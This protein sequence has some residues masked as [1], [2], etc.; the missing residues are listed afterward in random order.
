ME[1]NR[2]VLLRMGGATTRMEGRAPKALTDLHV[3]GIVMGSELLLKEDDCEARPL[4]SSGDFLPLFCGTFKPLEQVLSPGAV[5]L[6]ATRK[7]GSCLL[8][9]ALRSFAR[10]DSGSRV[11]GEHE[12]EAVPLS[13]KPR[14]CT[15][16]GNALTCS[17]LDFWRRSAMIVVWFVELCFFLDVLLPCTKECNALIKSEETSEFLW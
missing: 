11:C 14:I 7:R 1:G 2:A 8:F 6:V 10:G 4:S 15:G 16:A 12:R 5:T 13:L 3:S 9:C 17:K